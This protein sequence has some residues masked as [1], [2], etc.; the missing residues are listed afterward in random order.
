MRHN[1]RQP[2]AP[3]SAEASKY[4]AGIFSS[5]VNSGVIMNGSQM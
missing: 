2:R 1:V 4:E 3:R 5:A